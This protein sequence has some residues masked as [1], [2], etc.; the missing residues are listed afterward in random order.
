MLLRLSWVNIFLK[1]F[2]NHQFRKNFLD[3]SVDQG[4]KRGPID[5]RESYF[6][7][8]SYTKQHFLRPNRTY[9]QVALI[10]NLTYTEVTLILENRKSKPEIELCGGR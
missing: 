10:P 2:S 1:M 7:Q 3:Y 5:A 6:R 4:R 9:N 8:R